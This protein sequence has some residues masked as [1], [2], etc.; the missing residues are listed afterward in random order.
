MSPAFFVRLS[1]KTD[2]FWALL[3]MSF[4]NICLLRSDRRPK[5]TNF[6][7]SCTVFAGCIL[8]LSTLYPHFS[9]KSLNFKKTENTRR[10]RVFRDCHKF[11]NK[12]FV[13]IY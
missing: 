12:N 10:D 9:L 11:I 1:A 8:L 2:R 6:N 5:Q 13:K 3:A 4:Q 7:R